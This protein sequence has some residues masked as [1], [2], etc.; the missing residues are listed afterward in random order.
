MTTQL[1]SGKFVSND[2]NKELFFQT[3]RNKIDFFYSKL[4]KTSKESISCLEKHSLTNPIVLE[5]ICKDIFNQANFE[6]E[7]DISFNKETINYKDEITSN[8]IPIFYKVVKSMKEG[9]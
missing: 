1:V 3:N 4:E 6:I 8:L 7:Q 2:S 9:M 5:S